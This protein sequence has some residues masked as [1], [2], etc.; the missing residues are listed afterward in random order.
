MKYKIL[1][2][3]CLLLKFKEG[4]IVVCNKFYKEKE[5]IWLIMLIVDFND[6]FYGLFFNEMSIEFCF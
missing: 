1:S 4:I 6:K 3:L 2:V 5:F